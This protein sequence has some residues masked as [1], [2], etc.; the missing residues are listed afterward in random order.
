MFTSKDI[1]TYEYIADQVG[2]VVVNALEIQ[3]KVDNVFELL[4]KVKRA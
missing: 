3:D 2:A 4:Q 1:L